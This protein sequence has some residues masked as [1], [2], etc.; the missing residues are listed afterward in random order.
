MSERQVG[1]IDRVA[2]VPVGDGDAVQDAG[3]AL[4][5]GGAAA[6]GDGVRTT[7]RLDQVVVGAAL[8]ELR[9][10]GTLH[11]VLMVRIQAI[12]GNAI[13]DRRGPVRGTV[14]ADP[15]SAIGIGVV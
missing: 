11:Q 14:D 8:Q 1:D 15:P 7:V 13:R 6:A 4:N 9:L 12:D 5:V 2:L 3:A 10:A